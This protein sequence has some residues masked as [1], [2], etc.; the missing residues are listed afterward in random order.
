ML[1][2][3]FASHPAMGYPVGPATPLDG[4]EKSAALVVK[5]TVVGEHVVSD[6]W[7]QT[8]MGFEVRETELRVV[9]VLKGPKDKLVRFRHYASAPG[10]VSGYS[11]QS[12][13]FAPGRT[14][15]VF[16]TKSGG[17]YRQ[18]ERNHTM[19]VDQGLVL[20]A[21]DRPHRGATVREAVWN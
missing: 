19:K 13:E 5:G 18:L 7:F 1:V 15:I 6:P 3:I 17:A 8:L 2:A 21:D 4:L 14:Y 12:Y 10:P 20:A 11:P 16:A 9:S